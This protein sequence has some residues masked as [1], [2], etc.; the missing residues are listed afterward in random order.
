MEANPMADRGGTVHVSCMISRMP[1][2]ER[3]GMLGEPG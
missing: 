3:L 1:S 2:R